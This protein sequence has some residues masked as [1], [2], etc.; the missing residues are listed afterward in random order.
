VPAHI[1]SVAAA[2]PAARESAQE[3]VDPPRHLRGGTAREG[4]E[5]DAAR[6]GAVLDQERD[7]MC[8]RRGLA[9]TGSGDDEQ[10]PGLANG[11]TAVFG[12]TALLRI[13]FFE[14][15]RRH[16]PESSVCTNGD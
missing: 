5:H 14:A 1:A 12:G 10:R 7:T 15:P 13:E 4:Q 16:R 6:V 11:R 9:R 3:A 8:Q 2:A